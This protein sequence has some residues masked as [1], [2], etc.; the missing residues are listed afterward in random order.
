MPPGCQAAI[1][2]YDELEDEE[3]L[4]DPSV[5]PFFNNLEL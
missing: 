4:L 2:G 1:F 3:E 5:F